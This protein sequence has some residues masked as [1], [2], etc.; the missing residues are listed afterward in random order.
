MNFDDIMREKALSEQRIK[1]MQEI[2]ALANK[3]ISHKA[4]PEQDLAESLINPVKLSQIHNCYYV[5]RV[6]G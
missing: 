4:L 5:Y 2:A 6:K 3:G 1:V